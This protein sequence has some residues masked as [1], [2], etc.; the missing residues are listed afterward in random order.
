MVIRPEGVSHSFGSELSDLWS[1]ENWVTSLPLVPWCKTNKALKTF[2]MTQFAALE[3]RYP[4]LCGRK[5][6]GRLFSWLFINYKAVLPLKPRCSRLIPWNS[7]GNCLAS[8]SMHSKSLNKGIHDHHNTLGSSERFPCEMF[9]ARSPRETREKNFS[10]LKRLHIFSLRSFTSREGDWWLQRCS[11][12]QL[13]D[14]NTD[15]HLPVN[16]FAAD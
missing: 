11:F 16:K 1:Y 2:F 5:A 4:F 13:I 12:W 10:R 7:N 3:R 9:S 15:V 14:D 8:F 6:W